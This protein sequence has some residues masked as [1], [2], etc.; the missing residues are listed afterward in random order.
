MLQVLGM[1]EGW[2]VVRQLKAGQS[3]THTH[4]PLRLHPR[5]R[6]SD[7]YFQGTVP[8]FVPLSRIR[9]NSNTQH[10]A[11]M[12]L[13][14][15]TFLRAHSAQQSKETSPQGLELLKPLVGLGVGGAEAEA[16]LTVQYPS[17]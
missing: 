3:L 6:L 15:S 14:W 13:E 16:P 7:L 12:P 10:R 4:S 17:P 1:N 11:A 8:G 5:G 2:A 9:A